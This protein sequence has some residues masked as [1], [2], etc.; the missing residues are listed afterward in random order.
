MFIHLNMLKHPA[1][2]ARCVDVLTDSLGPSECLSFR[3]SSQS[4]R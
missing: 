1:Y 4:P 2:S 3:G